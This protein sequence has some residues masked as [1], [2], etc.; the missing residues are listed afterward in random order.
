MGN[1]SELPINSVRSKGPKWLIGLDQNG[2]WVVMVLPNL[3]NNRPKPPPEE[4]KTLNQSFLGLGEL[5]KPD[6]LSNIKID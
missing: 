2:K 4:R 6:G 3:H 1:E 5:G